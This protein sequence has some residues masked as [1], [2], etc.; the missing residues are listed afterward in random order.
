MGTNFSIN[1]S[2]E[3]VR[4]GAN[5]WEQTLIDV[6]RVGA[7]KEDILAAYKAQ[8]RCYKLCKEFSPR[9]DYKEVVERLQL[10]HYPIELKKAEIG[11]RYVATYWWIVASIVLGCGSLVMAIGI[12]YDAIESTYFMA[13]LC[14]GLLL[15]ALSVAMGFFVRY[16]LKRLRGFASAIKTLK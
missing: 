2:G 12:L 11:K 3:I 9:P 14:W 7:A 4:D 15:L 13:E 6:I 8:K 16:L 10:D 5:G 1:N